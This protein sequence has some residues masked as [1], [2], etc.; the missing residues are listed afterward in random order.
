MDGCF[1]IM[2]CYKKRD[3]C[4]NLGAFVFFAMR[5]HSQLVKEIQKYILE[6]RIAAVFAAEFELRLT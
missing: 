3:G 2:L 1:C 5:Y 4:S 6:L